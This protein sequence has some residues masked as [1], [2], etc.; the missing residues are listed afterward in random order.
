MWDIFV[1]IL[2]IIVC[3]IVPYRLTFVEEENLVADLIFYFFDILFFIDM[4][5]S[6]FTTIPDEENMSEIT[7]RRTIVC[8]YLKTW[9][10]IDF[11]SILP[12]ALLMK[13]F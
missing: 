7:D 9:F 1:S 11:I 5:M 3:V 12:I 4:I 10:P 13:P 8:N 6:F 2:L